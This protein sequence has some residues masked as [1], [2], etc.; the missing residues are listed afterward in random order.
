MR[1][2]AASDPPP[3]VVINADD[4]GRSSEVNRAI[5]HCFDHGLISSATIMT[6]MPGFEEACLLVRDGR[7]E[8][9]IGVHLNLTQGRALTAPIHGCIRLC[10]PDGELGGMPRPVWRL[11]GQESHAIEVELS[12]QV[13]ALLA[14]GISPS[15]FDSHHHAHTQWPVCTIVMRLARRYGVQA[16]RLSRNCGTDPPLA[17]RVYKV[18]FNARLARAGLSRTRYFGSSQD[19]GLIARLDGPLEIMVHPELDSVGRVVDVSP[20]ADSLESVAA[21]WAGVGSLRCY[22]ELDS[23]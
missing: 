21:R 17:K 11:S 19:A 16:I 20:G 9:R 1:P 13:E 2:G 4:F 18:A 12:A 6:N 8:D 15:H 22:R 3:A 23:I 14:F 10:S 5:V 7:F